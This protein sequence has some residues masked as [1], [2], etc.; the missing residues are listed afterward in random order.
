MES[1]ES[2]RFQ[3]SIIETI[4]LIEIIESIKEVCI[5]DA[6]LGDAHVWVS[7]ASFLAF[8]SGF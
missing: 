3:D 4:E 8:L 1:I 6:N 7:W 2:N 5:K